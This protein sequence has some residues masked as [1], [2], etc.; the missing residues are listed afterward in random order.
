MA[1]KINL[2]KKLAEAIEG[3][4]IRAGKWVQPCLACGIKAGYVETPDGRKAQVQIIVTADKN[5]WA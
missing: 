2:E 5:E 4:V 3:T 1:R